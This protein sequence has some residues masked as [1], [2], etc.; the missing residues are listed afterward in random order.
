MNLRFGGRCVTMLLVLVVPVACVRPAEPQIAEELP[1]RSP[2]ATATPS[3]EPRNDAIEVVIAFGRAGDI[4]AATT[5]GKQV[6]LTR[7]R[8]Q[9]RNP[10]ISFDGTS[11]VFERGRHLVELDLTDGSQRE[12]A[13]GKWP[14]YGPRGY[15]AW[16]NEAGEVVVGS[17]DAGEIASRPATKR[18]GGWVEHLAWDQSLELLYYEAVIGEG[19]VP[20]AM[21]VIRVDGWRCASCGGG[22]ELG[23]SKSIYP[24]NA[25]ASEEFLSTSL[26]FDAGVIRVCCRTSE[27]GG[28]QEAE[29]G[30]IEYFDW[31][32]RYHRL[33][34][35]DDVPLDLSGVPLLLR[36]AGR[37]KA[38][39]RRGDV[40][41]WRTGSDTVWL[42][43]DSKRLWLVPWHGPAIELPFGADA[44]AAVSPKH[45][46]SLFAERP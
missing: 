7:T 46:K 25:R 42:V 34:R 31:G 38:V 1:R 29:I 33:R 39:L 37:L 40:V 45:S 21:D 28:W 44:G 13:E 24:D 6:N 12:V 5:A 2:S 10:T 17:S 22:L 20:Y 15:L 32:T 26:S 9:E 4:W 41:R 3:A 8:Q 36:D 19:A 27:A 43:G 30:G 14:T 23:S 35:L 16:T 18:G 11:V